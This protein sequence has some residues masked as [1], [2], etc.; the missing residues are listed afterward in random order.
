MAYNSFLSD[1]L[2]ITDIKTIM[3]ITVII[4]VFF[5]IRVLERKK[6]EYNFSRQK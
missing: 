4:G 6:L 2:M 5:T 1:F 3:F